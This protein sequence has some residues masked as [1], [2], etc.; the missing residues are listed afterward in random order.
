MQL[1]E[2]HALF[3]NNERECVWK[4]LA[5]RLFCW[6]QKLRFY[7]LCVLDGVEN[8]PVFFFFLFSG[9]RE[10]QSNLASNSVCGSSALE[11]FTKNTYSSLL[12]QARGQERRRVAAVT[13]EESTKVPVQE[14]GRQLAVSGS[15]GREGGAKLLR[16][17]RS[18]HGLVED[19]GEGGAG[20]V[21]VRCPVW[22]G[23][24][25]DH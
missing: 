9:G 4:Q 20:Q 22:K 7:D 8:A 21:R 23:P 24:A 17:N 11:S 10:R 18:P 16:P 1:V 25:V 14:G 12:H 19:G 15:G 6:C 2:I 13:P 5:L 3:R